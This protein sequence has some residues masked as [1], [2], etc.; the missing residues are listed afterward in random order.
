MLIDL[1]LQKCVYILC[2]IAL[3][4]NELLMTQLSNDL[5]DDHDVSKVI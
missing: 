3:L 5:N 2:R 1:G 4:E